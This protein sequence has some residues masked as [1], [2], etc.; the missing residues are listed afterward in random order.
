MYV[1]LLKNLVMF[2]VYFERYVQYLVIYIQLY[3]N[4]W[5]VSWH[6]T[7]WTQPRKSRAK[8]GFGFAIRVGFE[9][10]RGL[11]RW[12]LTGQ[13]ANSKADPD[14]RSRPV[15]RIRGPVYITGLSIRTTDRPSWS[16]H[17]PIS[18]PTLLTDQHI[19]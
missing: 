5:G 13:K 8:E 14:F 2:T 9:S 11:L 12:A 4:V 16:A 3:C 10:S 7:N 1:A 19:N 15:K 6:C 18:I 17:R